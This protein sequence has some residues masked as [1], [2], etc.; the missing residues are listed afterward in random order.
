M[1]L[2]KTKKSKGLSGQHAKLKLMKE[3]EARRLA[4]QAQEALCNQELQH[5]EAEALEYKTWERSVEADALQQGNE[6]SGE[7]PGK[8]RCMLTVELA[9]GS[10]DAPRVVQTVG[11]ELPLN[12]T[13]IMIRMRAELEPVPS[14]VRSLHGSRRLNFS[15]CSATCPGGHA[16]RAAGGEHGRWSLARRPHCCYSDGGPKWHGDRSRRGDRCA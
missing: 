1:I 10:T 16:R 3:D 13:P 6:L 11:M 9:T 5:L 4:E 8:R 15:H 7:R 2:S 12:G 14:E